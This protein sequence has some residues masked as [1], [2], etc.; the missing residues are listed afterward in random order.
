[1]APHEVV[2]LLETD[3]HRGLRASEAT[4][5]LTRFGPNV[6]P[7]AGGAGFLLRI[8][9]QF[10]HPLVYS[11]IAASAVTAVLNEYIDSA[12]IFGVVL[13]NAV[14]GDA[15]ESSAGGFRRVAVYGAHPSQGRP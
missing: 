4:E 10:H 8:A 11:L 14:V 2:L 3:P 13:V 1:M 12:V 6:L 15:Q 7:A 9:R 5:R